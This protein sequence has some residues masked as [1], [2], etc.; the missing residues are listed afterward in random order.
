MSEDYNRIKDTKR[1]S[2]RSTCGHSVVELVNNP[3]GNKVKTEC[4]FYTE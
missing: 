2:I 1:H 3:E 4:K